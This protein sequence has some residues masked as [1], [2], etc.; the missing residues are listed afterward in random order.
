MWCGKRDDMKALRAERTEK[1]S[2]LG[3][4]SRL[5][6]GLGFGLLVSACSLLP[7]TRGPVEVAEQAPTA[8][9]PEAEAEAEAE[10][11]ASSA[12][13][14]LR[15]RRVGDVTVH[16]FSGSYVQDPLLLTERVVAREGDLWVLDLT[17]EDVGSRA[18]LRVRLNAEGEVKAAARL[19]G[20][21]EIPIALADYHA[22]LE[23]TV[24]A[25]DSNEGLLATTRGTCLVGPR[26][27]EC[28][29]KSYKVR[30]LDQ[31]A[32]LRVSASHELPGR[33]LDGELKTNDGRLVYRSELVSF[34]NQA[35]TSSVAER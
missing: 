10:E 11:K 4:M 30:L 3:R 21:S 2:G 32:T 12:G 22:F 8:A 14:E 9:A 16:R 24:L 25:A 13:S 34:E 35:Q 17:L 20:D 29:T 7:A 33:D 31:F 23:R 6:T 28:E 27:L 5:G 1:K 15:V 26:E 18:Q 19:E